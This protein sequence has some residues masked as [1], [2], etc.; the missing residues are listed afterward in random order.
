MKNT[1]LILT[2]TFSA[3]SFAGS[4]EKSAVLAEM[5]YDQ[6]VAQAT[7]TF[8][9]SMEGLNGGQL[10]AVQRAQDTFVKDAMAFKIFET[11]CNEGTKTDEDKYECYTTNYK[12][13]ADQIVQE[14]ALDW[15]RNDPV[16][17]LILN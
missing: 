16:C 12:L 3:S 8:N 4:L 14:F 17:K 13:G 10:L 9:R 1:I 6:V 15:M 2:L 11:G 7:M 5:C